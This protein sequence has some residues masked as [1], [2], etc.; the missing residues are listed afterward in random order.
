MSK[1]IT[2]DIRGRIINAVLKH[3]HQEGAV[4]LHVVEQSIAWRAYEAL[5]P[6]S[7]RATMR[8]LQEV[9]GARAFNSTTAIRTNVGGQ[10]MAL[11]SLHSDTVSRQ[12]PG[13]LDRHSFLLLAEH[14]NSWDPILTLEVGSELA[15][16]ISD[17]VAA[18]SALEA[19]IN[20]QRAEIGG[21]LSNTRTVKQL[22]IAWP[23][24]MPIASQFLTVEPP[25]TQLPATIVSVLNAKLGLPPAELAD[26]A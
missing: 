1:I 13:G 10:R 24:V 17:H 2:N 14:H 18:V 7:I 25:K 15:N 6:K 26:A 21:I 23:D 9:A 12:L 5:Y 11:G 8:D 16:D 4:A 22:E 3:A 19:T 20:E